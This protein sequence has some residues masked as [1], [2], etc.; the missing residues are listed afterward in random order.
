MMLPGIVVILLAFDGIAPGGTMV[1]RGAATAVGSAVALLAYAIWPT[2]EHRRV[3][4]ALAAMLDAYRRYFATLLADDLPARIAA[5]SVARSTRTNAQASLDRLRGEPR[6]DR[7]LLAFA[8]GV[9]ANANR[10]V[11]ACMSL[12]AALQDARGLPERAALA[13][14]S[15]RIEVRLA[16]LAAALRGEQADTTDSADDQRADERSV[17]ERLGAAIDEQRAGLVTEVIDT[18]DR[19]TDSIDTLAH[20]VTQAE[21]GLRRET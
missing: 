18:F 15:T 19:M 2:W 3:R 12:E 16:A 17:A 5:R 11:R 20:V 4:P 14:F 7:R 1:A 21:H 9:F 8:E 13:A 6:P 10:F